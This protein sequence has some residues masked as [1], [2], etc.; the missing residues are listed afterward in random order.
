MTVEMRIRIILAATLALVLASTSCSLINSD[1]LKSILQPEQT[2]EPAATD[3]PEAGVS[4]IHPGTPRRLTT[5]P[6]V[7]LDPAWD[8]RG[9]TI[10]F[11]KG[12]NEERPFDIGAVSPEGTNERV[13]ATGPNADIGIGGE[14]T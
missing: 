10:A 12:K 3:T 13:I 5:T 14:L 11:M 4:G 1:E 2:N 7:E 6:T 9:G 8:P